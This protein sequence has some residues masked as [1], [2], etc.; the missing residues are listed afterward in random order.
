VQ[1]V[2]RARYANWS[3]N[4]SNP[5]QISTARS[6]RG[7]F[8][9]WIA[10]VFGDYALASELRAL[11]ERYRVTADPDTV[12]KMANAIRARYDLADE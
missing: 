8:S 4:W 5:W 6:G 1:L 10:D 12:P 9:R 7:D 11:E 2:G 3:P